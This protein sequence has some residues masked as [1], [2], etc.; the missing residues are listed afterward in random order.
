MDI[1][2]NTF[3]WFSS[4][5]GNV[6][7]IYLENVPS[8][9]IYR[10]LIY[11]F[12]STYVSF[13]FSKAK[14]AY[15]LR[16]INVSSPDIT[17]NTLTDLGS[18]SKAY[19]LYLDSVPNAIIQNITIERVLS[20]SSF[21]I[22]LLSSISPS[23]EVDIIN[24]SINDISSSATESY[25][26]SL[27]SASNSNIINNTIERIDSPSLLYVVSII[28]SPYITIDD[29]ILD[30]FSSSSPV[31]DLIG[32]NL[33]D[34]GNS[35]IYHNDITY[36]NSPFS[37][38][39]A[40]KL[41]NSG[42]NEIKY[43]N[44]F[45]ITTQL[46]SAFGIFVNSSYNT[47]IWLNNLTSIKSSSNA[48][49]SSILKPNTMA[50]DNAGYGFVLIN[51]Y[52]DISLNTLE[53]VT[54]WVT[55]DESSPASF[56]QNIVDS[57]VV[58]FQ[59]ITHPVDTALSEGA[60]EN[61]TWVAVDESAFTYTIVVDGEVDTT[62]LWLSEVPI[63][64]GLSH[65]TLGTYSVQLVITDLL[66]RQ[67]SDDVVVTVTENNSPIFT[68]IPLNITY[69]YESEGN[70]V[71]WIASDAHPSVYSIFRNDTEIIFSSWDT[72]V[73]ITQ[74][75]DDLEPG[76]YE[77]RIEIQDTSE[78]VNKSTVSVL[79]LLP[80]EI[81]FSE[82]PPDTDFIDAGNIVDLI[83]TIQ[84]I[85]GGNYTIYQDGVE[86][87]KGVWLPG[88]PVNLTEESLRV[89]T[90][91][92]YIEFTD[93]FGNLI[94][95]T[96]IINVVNPAIS[97]TTTSTTS[98]STES[99]FFD[100]DFR[101]LGIDNTTLIILFFGL[102]FFVVVIIF[103]INRR[104]R[105]KPRTYVSKNAKVKKLGELGTAYLSMG[106]N[107]NA[108]KCFKRML[109]GSIKIEDKQL[110]GEAL[111]NLG[112]AGLAL[113]DVNKELTIQYLDEALSIAR[114]IGD[115]HLEGTIIGLL[116]DCN[117]ITRNPKEAVNYYQK[118]IQIIHAL[119]DEKTGM[120]LLDN[121]SQTYE[122]MGDPHK[123]I[124]NYEEALNLAKSTLDKLKEGDLNVKIANAYRDLD[125]PNKAFNYYERALK[126]TRDMGNKSKQALVQGDLGLA[127]L[128]T[129]D[130]KKAIK[131]MEDAM[132]LAK[133]IDDKDIELIQHGN[134]GI[135]YFKNGEYD[136]AIISLET[137]L[138]SMQVPQF[139]ETLGDTFIAKDDLSKALVSYQ[140][141]V[142]LSRKMGEKPLEV[143]LLNKIVI[144]YKGN[145][146]KEKE[147]TEKLEKAKE[148]LKDWKSSIASAGRIS[149]RRVARTSSVKDIESI[150]SKTPSKKE[151]NKGSRNNSK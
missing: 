35:T 23:S 33:L 50:G 30:N 55:F 102:I 53:D 95:D 10:N 11:Q 144:A 34:S 132:T 63:I 111:K 124:K 42:D 14:F 126:I 62:G 36:L 31:Y 56:Y 65:L 69:L 79:V 91:N 103:F 106:D 15:G 77:F 101:E 84:S 86:K 127:Y 54:Y 74:S 94:T 45:N 125:E 60:S 1:I 25:G 22:F 27:T 148:E 143:N 128:N 136:K 78:N 130:I 9:T 47:T 112:S 38:V 115:K 18:N 89:G 121:L 129:G 64:F 52:A 117:R 113:K 48:L 41:E 70:I 61:L 26:I 147:F 24:N 110:Q 40:I 4:Q 105:Y 140:K 59:S 90:Y 85:K 87:V 67:I 109:N 137:A 122:M 46:K 37:N 139:H 119:D 51:T 39:Y 123:A 75:I 93:I 20:K 66:G 146:S 138:K 16:L 6:T 21:G 44:I 28:N 29:N 107:F 76:F 150:R 149:S 13:D 19:A 88:V 98:L 114:K 73:P 151:E 72:D 100:F 3:S 104:T 2:N 97:S 142:K 71:S 5:E 83:W 108:V 82:I 116:G 135:A 118:A 49:F 8:P 96:V 134:I 7:G 32:I 43:N 99:Q 131:N 81:Q 141:G 133:V 17:F 145:E 92:F 12:T 57:N 68:D 58:T 120:L 80:T